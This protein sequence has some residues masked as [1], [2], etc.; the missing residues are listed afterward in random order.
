MASLQAAL[1]GNYGGALE[2]PPDPAAALNRLNRHLHDYVE[3]TR[4]VTL[5]LV[6]YV[7]G[8]KIV[9]CNAG[10]NPA[11]RVRGN[12]VTWLSDGG[13]MLG[14]FPEREYTSYTLPVQSGDLV[15][16]Y[17]DGVTEAMDPQGELYGEEQLARVLQQNSQRPI[18]EIRTAILA[19][20]RTWQQGGA[21]TDDVTLVLLRIGNTPV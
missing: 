3:A 16:L 9:Y 10:H 20:V 7:G 13:L 12:E 19:S 8:D 11:L 17:T 6:R 2:T 15:C 14:P 1:R 4:F 21:V 5:F 18:Q